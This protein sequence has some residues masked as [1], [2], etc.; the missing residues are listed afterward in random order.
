L[1][2]WRTGCQPLEKWIETLKKILKANHGSARIVG[3]LAEMLREA[4]SGVDD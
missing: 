4:G 2:T 3:R 1:V